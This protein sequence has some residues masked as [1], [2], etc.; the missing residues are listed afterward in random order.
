LIFETYAGVLVPECPA[1][2]AIPRVDIERD[3]TNDHRAPREGYEEKHDIAHLTFHYEVR[4]G[5]TARCLRALALA[6]SANERD[7]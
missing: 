4:S 5:A 7:Q 3:K 2:D 1:L 6:S